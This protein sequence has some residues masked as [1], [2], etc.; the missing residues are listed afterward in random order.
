MP[1]KVIIKILLKKYF[2]VAAD[3]K[4][5]VGTTG[6][7]NGPSLRETVVFAVTFDDGAGVVGQ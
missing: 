1:K 6:S 2:A 7:T 4:G 5:F 3:A